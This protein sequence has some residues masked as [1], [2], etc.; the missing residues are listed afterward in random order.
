MR[1]TSFLLASVLC[2]AAS[3]L[4]AE[5]GVLS[6]PLVVSDRWPEATDLRTWTEDVMRIE[7]VEDASETE[8]G[9][10]FFRWVRLFSKMAT[11]GMIQAFEGPYGKENFVTDAHKTMFVYGW[12]YCDTSSR[13]AEAAWSEYKRDRRTAERVVVQHEGGGF[14]TMYRLNL[15]GNWGAFDPRYG[16]YLVDRDAPDARILDWAEVGKDDNIRANKT[17]KHRSGPFFEFFGREWD[18]AFLIEPTYFPDEDSWRKAGEPIENVL[19]NSQYQMGTPFHDM[20]FHLPKGMTIERFWDNSARKFYQPETARATREE[21]FLPAGRFYRVTETMFDGNWPKHDPNYAKAKPYLANVPEDEGYNE[22]VKGGRTIGQAWGRLTYEPDLGSPEFTEILTDD[23]DLVHSQTA[24]YLRTTDPSKGGNATLDFYSPYILVDGVF[25][26][27]LMGAR[28][29]A[30]IEF[31][32][33]QAKAYTARDPD[34]WSDWLTLSDKPGTFEVTLNRA[35]LTAGEPSLHGAYR[36][37]V[38]VVVSPKAKAGVE[39]GLKAFKLTSHFETGIMSIPQIFAG[40]NKI[41]FK[42][43][44]AS[45]VNGPIRVTYRYETQAGEQSH[46]QALTARDFRNNEAAYAINAPGLIRCT[47]LAVSY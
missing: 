36:F 46:E 10:A 16:Y 33:L 30:H 9:K 8:Q 29:D 6:G 35:N 40:R 27:E 20:S 14:H 15:D 44:D 21:P 26:G 38:R 25:S 7:D 1:K 2:L 41:R 3:I 45:K 18:R 37:Q 42:L 32:S 11:G 39:T 47:S 24:P 17:F 12:G 43:A 34:I 13:I 22:Q 31:R 4:H 19:G 23:S 28:G 5:P